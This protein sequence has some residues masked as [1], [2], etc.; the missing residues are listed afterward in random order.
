MLGGNVNGPNPPVWWAAGYIPA[1]GDAVKVLMVD[2]TALV[3]GPV[4]TDARPLTGVAGTAA[5][6]LVPITVGSSV[7]QA[8]YTGAAP[9]VGSLVRLDWQGTQP[10]AWQG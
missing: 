5:G 8:R 7:Y 3:H 2:G 4:I 10:W 9:V 6:G 1:A